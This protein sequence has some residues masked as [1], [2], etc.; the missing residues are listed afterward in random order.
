[1]N[2]SAANDMDTPNKSAMV[3]YYDPWPKQYNVRASCLW[4][5]TEFGFKL[6]GV[7]S[8]YGLTFSDKRSGV[9]CVKNV[10][11]NSSSF[12]LT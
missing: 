3:E 2:G 4:T 5:V 8:V 12:H 11:L 7:F 10:L 1:M 9:L 6:F